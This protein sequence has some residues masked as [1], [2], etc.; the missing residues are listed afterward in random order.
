MT[1]L[2]DFKLETYLAKWEFG[3]RYHM[4]ASDMETM[5][6]SELLAL[7]EPDDR[8]AFDTMRLSYI[9]TTGTAR[10]RSAIAATYAGLEPE[11]VLAFAGAEE[12][13]FCAMHAVLDKDSHAVIVTPNYQSSETLP[14]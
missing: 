14:L 2:P 13:I 7:A 3:A 6:M 4:T 8:R 1:M 12:G 9:E 5:T 11:D 10:L